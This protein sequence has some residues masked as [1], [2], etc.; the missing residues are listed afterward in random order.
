MPNTSMESIDQNYYFWHYDTS[1]LIPVSTDFCAR[2]D[3]YLRV[4][5]NIP[6]VSCLGVIVNNNWDINSLGS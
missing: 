3:C 2:K 1:V 4:L 5:L 6:I